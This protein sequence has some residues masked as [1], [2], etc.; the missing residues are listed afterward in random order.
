M[1]DIGS[2][3]LSIVVP[4]YNSERVLPELCARVHAVMETM[5][6]SYELIL[7]D[8]GSRDQSFKVCS[9]EAQSDERIRVIKMI[10]NFGQHPAITAGLQQSK[11]RWVVLMDDDMQSPPEEIPKLYEKALQGFDMVVGAREKREDSMLRKMGSSVAHWLMTK[12]FLGQS[13]DTISSFR[14]LSRRLVNA[15][16]Q[17][18][19]HHSYVAALLSWLGFPQ[20][21]VLVRHDASKVGASRYSFKKLFRIWMDMAI[22]FSD[23]PLRLATWLGLVSSLIAVILGVRVVLLYFFAE[24]PIPG[25]AS[26]FAAQTFFFGITMLFLG[27]HGE[28]IARILREVKRRPYFLIDHV[29]SIRAIPTP[30]DQEV[31]P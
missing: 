24:S 30:F 27:V 31:R 20:A 3:E 25:Y 23:R 5:K 11:G 8:D 29:K 14:I 28:Y 21:T 12:L 26:L 22:G 4:V 10:R 19:E 13:K 6:I 16:L 2:I 15:Y 17:L 18:P 9:Q 1:P 7:V